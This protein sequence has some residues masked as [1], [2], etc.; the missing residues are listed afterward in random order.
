MAVGQDVDRG[1]DTGGGAVDAA[2]RDATGP[3]ATVVGATVSEFEEVRPAPPLRRYVHSYC[4]YRLAGFGPGIHVGMPSRHLT[5]ILTIDEPLDVSGPIDPAGPVERYDTLIGGLHD[6]PVHIHHDGFQHGIQLSLTPLGAR[7][8]FGVPSADL[9]STVVALDSVLGRAAGE[10]HERLHDAATWSDRFAVVDEVLGRHLEE[11][12]P[13]RP[14]V[15]GTWDLLAA[16]AGGVAV[17]DIA[18]ELGWSRRHLSAVFR[19][20]IGLSPKVV[21]RIMRFERSKDLVTA[22]APSL[23]DV[24]ARSGYADQAHLAR[25]WRDL[26]GASPTAWMRGEEFPIVQ[27]ERLRT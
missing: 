10:I 25:D 5:V 13:P 9:A 27:D 23:A 12:R 15:I 26:A 20:E 17:S 6:G 24:A 1:R 4:G 11:P 2:E 14:E 19:D 16:T 18:R 7:A 22:G 3:D 8:L 21:G